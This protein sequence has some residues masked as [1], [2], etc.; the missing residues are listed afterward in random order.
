[1]DR[2]EFLKSGAFG[3]TAL[4]VGPGALLPASA[5][6][7]HFPGSGPIRL[8]LREVL[9]EMVD[10]TLAYMWAYDAGEPFG[11]RIPGP[12]LVAV[13]GDRIRLE[14]SNGLPGEHTFAVPGVVEPVPL[15][16][17]LPVAIEFPA[18]DPG[19]YLYLDAANPPVNR[20]LGLHGALVVLPRLGSA[21]YR[22]EDLPPLP[23]GDAHPVRALFDDLG[24]AD[25]GFPGHFWEPGRTWIWIFNTIDPARNEAVRSDPSLP[26]AAF[27]A[28]YRPRYFT[29]NGKSGFFASHDHDIAPHGRVG[30]P[31]LLRALNA[32]LATHSPHIHG[33]HVFE[34]AQN[35]RVKGNVVALDTWALRPLDRKD[36][37]LPFIRPPDVPADAPVIGQD[38][39]AWPPLEEGFPQAFPMHCHTEFSQTAAGG[40]YP[41]GVVTDFV[42]EGDLSP[43]DEA[44]AVDRAD[45]RVRIGRLTLAGR[46]SGAA[47]T[48]LQ[49]RAGTSPGGALL[50][51]TEVLGDGTWAFEGRAL[52]AV[53]AGAVT[54]VSPATGAVRAGVR[55]LLR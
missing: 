12:V 10:G 13:E 42:I 23:S 39:P 6:A 25:R 14:V 31:A 29:I 18:P 27:T 36:L 34:L 5:R 47:G 37:L 3:L 19:T 11:P 28:G 2:R 21:P 49:V 43:Q 8:A 9:A 50:G 15:P 38:R 55:L 22:R 40:N 20:A 54:V 41:Q 44:I 16:A 32:G 33:N 4:A 46:S 24:R 1:M 48:V 53:A 45:L 17:G 51:H 7:A 26:A 30:Q 52:A 35:G